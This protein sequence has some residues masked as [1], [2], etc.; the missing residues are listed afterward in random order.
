MANVGN[1]YIKRL[2]A[3]F[4]FFLRFFLPFWRFFLQFYLNVYYIC[5]WNHCGN[6]WQPL[7]R[8]LLRPAISHH[9]VCRVITA[10]YL[11]AVKRDGWSSLASVYRTHDP[12]RAHHRS[13]SS[14]EHASTRSIH[15]VVVVLP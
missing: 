3:F 2:Q 5:G 6:K 4:Y 7:F 13:Q 1:V 15:A 8:D 10:R 9:S 12:R 11:T 14:N